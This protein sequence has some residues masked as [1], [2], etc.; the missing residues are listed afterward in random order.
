MSD[1][2]SIFIVD[3]H[4]VVRDGLKSMLEIEN[5]IEIVGTAG[6]ATEA[7]ERLDAINPETPEIILMDIKM[8]GMDGI[9]LTK[10]I[11]QSNPDANIIMLTLYGEYLT[12]AIEAG[13][14]GYVLKDMKRD[15]LLK[16]IR[17]VKNGRSP[18]V[19]TVDKDSF[20]ELAAPKKEDESTRL[21]DRELTIMKLI[22]SGV[23]TRELA[24]QLFLS[25]ASIKRSVGIICRKLGV[26]NRSEAV[27]E[28]FRRG[29]I[30]YE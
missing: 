1:K 6:N 14:V 11:T 20:T 19:L 27:A 16:S 8:P 4:E 10:R 28:A 21:T 26:R 2:T 7:L 13:A 3:D 22:S 23:K 29:L 15:D 12:Q 9:E 30:T 17:A 25:E 24:D 18:L 5:D